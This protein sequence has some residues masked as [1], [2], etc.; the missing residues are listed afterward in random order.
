M[1]QTFET[2]GEDALSA[3]LRDLQ[4][5]PGDEADSPEA[6]RRIRDTLA[7]HAPSDR[8]S[9]FT[10]L[11]R[12]LYGTP[13]GNGRKDDHGDVREDAT[14][15]KVGQEVEGSVDYDFDFD[16]F[17]FEAEQGQKY[18]IMVTHETLP[19]SHI[20]F[21]S[22]INNHVPGWKSKL[23]T[24]AGIDIHWV[25][26]QS[27]P[28]L[29]AIQNFGGHRGSYTLS[30][31]RVTDPPDDH[32]DRHEEATTVELGERVEGEIHDAWDL[33][34]FR[35]KTVE[36]TSYVAKI[37]R[38]SNREACCIVGFFFPEGGQV[39]ER[40]GPETVVYTYHTSGWYW[41]VVHGGNE[42][43]TGS[44]VFEVTKDE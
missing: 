26:P 31:T 13:P 36:Q 11:Y 10:D 17:L 42:R 14:R 44:Y 9:E 5:R 21:L 15:I 22:T 16:F 37:E 38:D 34:F 32:P 43:K 6:E 7:R 39:T 40:G 12:R 29:L 8:T 2:I 4:V 30:V 19:A 1:L 25:G 24:E 27:A 35:V 28:Y 23:R 20:N 18:D 41:V 33:D 3:A